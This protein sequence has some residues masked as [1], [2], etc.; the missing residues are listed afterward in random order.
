MDQA[1]WRA[2]EVLSPHF[3]KEEEL[4]LPVISVTKK[5]AEGKISRDL[6]DCQIWGKGYW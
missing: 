2:D 3:Q 6:P 1:A 5:V 4:A